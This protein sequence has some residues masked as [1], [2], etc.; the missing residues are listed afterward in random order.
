MAMGRPAKPT[1]LRLIE[2]NPGK[3]PLPKGEPVPPSVPV[4]KP[5]WLTDLASAEW[6]RVA[7][8]LIKMHLLTDVDVMA[9]AGYCEAVSRF[10]LATKALDEFGA[11]VPAVREDGSFVK[12]PAAQL[13]RDALADIKALSQEFGMTPSS[14]GRINLPDATPDDIDGILS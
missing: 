3:R 7:P 11:L 6:D 2:G 12:N 5:P 10:M 1:A 14:R 8:Q 13:A 9:L 4:V